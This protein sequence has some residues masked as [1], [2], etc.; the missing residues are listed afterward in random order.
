MLRLPRRT[1][2]LTALVAQIG[3]SLTSSPGC[4]AITAAPAR[5]AG[6]DLRTNRQPRC[7]GADAGERDPG[8]VERRMPRAA[9][10]RCGR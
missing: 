10:K 3:T 2:E 4:Q 8:Y 9:G 7:A 5:R 6:V 1:Q